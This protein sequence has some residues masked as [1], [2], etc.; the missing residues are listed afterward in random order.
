[1]ISI[2][3]PVYKVEPYLRQCVDSILNQTYRDIEVLLIDDGSPDKCG[4]ICDEYTENDKRVRAFHTENRGLSAARNLG[5]CEAKG[6]YIGFVDSDDWIEPDMYEVLLK[7]MQET[8]A[9]IGVCGWWREDELHDDKRITTENC[10]MQ[11]SVYPDAQNSLQALLDGK[12][13][14]HVWNKLYKSILVKEVCFP[15]GKYY[16]DLSTMPR[17][18]AHSRVVCVLPTCKYHYRRR[19]NS[20]SKLH[21]AKNLIDCADAQLNRFSYF[22][23]EYPALY[24]RK[25]SV[26]LRDCADGISRV[27]RWWYIQSRMDKETYQGRIIELQQFSKEYL[28]PTM[29]GKLS[30]YLR[31]SIVFM[32]YRCSAS[33]AILHAMNKIYKIIQSSFN[34]S[35]MWE[36]L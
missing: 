29:V 28:S 26:L 14:V 6:E 27:W 19:E 11:L 33:F 20:I 2:I 32:K 8:S 3:V 22:Q 21:T 9:D 16:E 12:I 18:I 10:A 5:V 25:K 17:I 30:G 13:N 36:Y 1:M 23:T 24:M 31:V 35:W 4:E 34:H 15:E 7:R